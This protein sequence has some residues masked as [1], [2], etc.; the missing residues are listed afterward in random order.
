MNNLI[1]NHVPKSFKIIDPD[2][3]LRALVLAVVDQFAEL[4]EALPDQQLSL[5]DAHIDIANDCANETE[6]ALERFR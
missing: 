2:L 1:V 6:R 4:I 3:L 5:A